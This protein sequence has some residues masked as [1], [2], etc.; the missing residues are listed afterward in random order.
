V[1]GPQ[2]FFNVESNQAMA[3]KIEHYQAHTTSGK[4]FPFNR[5]N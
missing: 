4:N 2:F 5:L 1:L 3:E